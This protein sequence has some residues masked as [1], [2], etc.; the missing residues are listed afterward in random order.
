VSAPEPFWTLWNKEKY[1]ALPRIEPRPLSPS[2]YRLSYLGPKKLMTGQSQNSHVYYKME[3]LPTLVRFLPTVILNKRRFMMTA[4]T[5]DLTKDGS[6]SKVK[7]NSFS[8]EAHRRIRKCM[9]FRYTLFRVPVFPRSHVDFPNGFYEF[10]QS[11]QEHAGIVSQIRPSTYVANHY[12]AYNST[13]FSPSYRQHRYKNT[14]R[15]INKQYYFLQVVFDHDVT[16]SH[17]EMQYN[18]PNL[19]TIQ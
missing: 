17:V 10:P 5:S 13:L 8:S 1:L 19:V 4:V 6:V 15:E 3:F 14:N 18:D 7:K 16:Y 9:E 12:S 11:L 2:L